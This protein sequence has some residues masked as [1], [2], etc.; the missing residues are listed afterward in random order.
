MLS[1]FPVHG[2]S[3]EDRR[4]FAELFGLFLALLK[5]VKEIFWRAIICTLFGPPVPLPELPR[6]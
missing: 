4:V 1:R 2:V 5:H 6:G 3:D